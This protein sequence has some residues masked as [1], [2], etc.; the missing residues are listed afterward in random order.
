MEEHKSFKVILS[1]FK[2][3]KL[4]VLIAALNCY[5]RF[6]QDEPKESSD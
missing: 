4:Y 5:K 6:Y 1:S 3:E 2:I